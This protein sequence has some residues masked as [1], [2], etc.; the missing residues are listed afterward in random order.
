MPT[1]DH[2]SLIAPVYDHVFGGSRKEEWLALLELPPGAAVLDAGGGTG[3]VAQA[4]DCLSCKIFI[5]DESHPMLRQAKASPALKPV[6]SQ[7]EALPFPDQRFERILMVDALHHLR[8]QAQAGRELWRLLKPGGRIMIEEPDIRS[9]GVKILA[10]LEKLLGMRS[11]FLHP[12]RIAALFAGTAA[13][14]TTHSKDH[15]VWV[16]VERPDESAAQ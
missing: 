11:H 16:I 8:D 15:N 12:E 6:C 7:V 4:L 14:I 5:A 2:F 3:R 13:K 10:V 9:F 1:W